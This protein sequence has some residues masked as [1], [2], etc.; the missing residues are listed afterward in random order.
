MT[1]EHKPHILVV[2]D[3]P[4]IVQLIRQSLDKQG[5]E[6]QEATSGEAGLGAHLDRNPDLILLDIRLPGIDGFEVCR[7]IREE[8]ADRTT[9]I[10]MITGADDADSISQAY[11]LG[12]ND[13][14]AKPINF[15]LMA[16]R[17]Y[18]ALINHETD[19]VLRKSAHFQERVSQLVR[20]GYI[21]Y[22]Y[23]TETFV[24]SNPK[25]SIPHL[26]DGEYARHEIRGFLHPEDQMR[27]DML[28]LEK[29]Q[30]EVEL[31]VILP[32]EGQRIIRICCSMENEKK[33]IMHGAF[34]DITDHRTTK[35]LLTYLHSH[36]ELADMPNERVLL[37]R[38][39]EHLESHNTTAQSARL[40]QVGISNYR[41]LIAAFGQTGVDKIVKRIARDFKR[42]LHPL[43]GQLEAFYID[44]GRFSVIGTCK[45]ENDM[46]HHLKALQQLI[47]KGRH[48]DNQAIRPL[49]ACIGLI[50]NRDNQCATYYYQRSL[51]GFLYEQDTP[52]I[53]V[54]WLGEEDYN[55]IREEVLLEYDV[56]EALK[57]GEFDLYLQPQMT[58]KEQETVS[59]FEA[60]VR[61]V[62][63]NGQLRD[64][65]PADFLPA[66][67]RTGLM[68]SFGK[69]IINLAFEK[70]RAL[71]EAGLTVRLGINLD[72]QQF[73]D[74]QLVPFILS[75]LNN[76]DLNAEDFEFEITEE[77]AM[78]DLKDTLKKLKALRQA[79]FHLAIDDFGIGYSSMAYLM[80]FP[81][82][83]LKI[84]RTFIA[85]TQ[86]PKVRAILLSMVTLARGLNL[87]T[88]AEG[89]ET[90]RQRDLL[91]LI[92]VDFQQG[93]YYA[94][95]LPL[96]EAIVFAK[97]YN[98]RTGPH[99]A[100]T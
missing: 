52:G 43:Q 9:P 69:T 42:Y 14:I 60:L 63:D 23:D 96:Q 76:S 2:E 50:L 58:T 98:D 18:F 89:I 24:L 73:A 34:Q 44:E 85:D 27:M 97:S 56:K 1:Q 28:L 26:A 45:A 75:K 5:Y 86:N 80:E 35:N 70:A 88:V 82:T 49:S 36:S 32:R 3:E 40:A 38:L 54:H 19:V 95:A 67:A 6:I 81:L 4:A 61:W 33:L 15:A 91:D 77:T 11:E 12:A 13:F 68:V 64:C 84:D 57:N 71:K 8:R 29:K 59:G 47:E 20:V 90:A 83:T 74:D 72:A 25:N 93:F 39:G 94:R 66:I 99:E 48:V 79:G 51:F 10:I 100:L 55:E 30:A 65:S 46:D 78:V 21:G 53:G 17:V 37:Q 22:H 87:T 41:K 31:R 16:Q 92:G 62:D 7:V